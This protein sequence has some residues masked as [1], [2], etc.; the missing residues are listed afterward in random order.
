[1]STTIQ[2]KLVPLKKWAEIMFGEFA[3]HPNTLHRWVHEG[4]ISPR[5]Q[6]VGKNWFVKPTAEYRGG[7]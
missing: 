2:P 5:P 1:M 4:R 6:I 3:P 7:K